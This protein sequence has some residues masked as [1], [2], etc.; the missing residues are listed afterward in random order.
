[1]V[2]L[3]FLAIF[4]LTQLDGIGTLVATARQMPARVDHS[5]SF[6]TQALLSLGAIFCLPR[7]FQ[8]GAVE[9]ADVEDVRQARW[10]FSLYLALICLVVVPI[11]AAAIA[12]G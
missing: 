3:I 5:I 8:V 4:A 6:V 1:L 9:C 7:Q 12:A 10:W 2:A 11:A